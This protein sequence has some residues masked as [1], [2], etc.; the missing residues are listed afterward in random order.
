MKTVTLNQASQNLFD[1]I[2]ETITNSAPIQILSDM[3]GAVL[4]STQDWNALQESIYLSSVPNFKESLEKAENEE[5]VQA[6]EV[7]W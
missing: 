7:E 1:F 4:V 5:W 6:D 2:S 3:G